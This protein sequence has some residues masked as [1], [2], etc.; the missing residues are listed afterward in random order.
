MNW[1]TGCRRDRTRTQKCSPTDHEVIQF[2]VQEG[3]N[4]QR[5]TQNRFSHLPHD[6]FTED[7]YTDNT[8]RAFV[9]RGGA[10]SSYTSYEIYT[11][12]RPRVQVRY[13]PGQSLCGRA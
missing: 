5:P 6:H 11:R 7:I 8:A 3:S 1:V 13:R 9:S 2:R 12:R 4:L 10:Q